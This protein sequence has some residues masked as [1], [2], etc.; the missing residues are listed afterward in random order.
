QVDTQDRHNPF[1]QGDLDV[2]ACAAAQA[3]RAVELARLYQERRDVEAAAHIQQSFPPAERPAVEPLRVFD[4]YSPAQ[5][6]GGDYYDCIPLP[7]NR[8]AVALGDVAGQGFSA[9][10]LMARLSA[11]LRFCLATEAT[12]PDAVRR[13]S[14]VLTRSGTEDR[15]VTFAVAVLD[16]TT[17]SL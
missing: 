12:V 17:F 14:A 7:D 11:A 5:H 2:L 16:L 8:L 3:G 6:V 13:L 9:A 10:L 1:R 15:F 4:P